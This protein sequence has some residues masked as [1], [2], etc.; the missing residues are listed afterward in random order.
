MKQTFLALIAIFLL[1]ACSSDDDSN[2]D[3]QNTLDYELVISCEEP[4]YSIKVEVLD[5]NGNVLETQTEENE[6]GMYMSITQGSV[7]KIYTSGDDYSY[8]YYLIKPDQS[9]V[10]QGSKYCL[11]NCIEERSYE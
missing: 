11:D 3:N 7:F 6:A 4:M 9:Y 2:S 1:V 8:N 5:N 10:L